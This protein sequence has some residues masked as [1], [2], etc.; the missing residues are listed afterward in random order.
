MILRYSK[1]KFTLKAIF[2]ANGTK[3]EI[4]IKNSLEEKTRKTRQ[5]RLFDKV[6]IPPTGIKPQRCDA[7]NPVNLLRLNITILFCPN[8]VKAYRK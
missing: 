6:S 8:R 2:Y 1:L 4:L 3:H 5:E 7:E